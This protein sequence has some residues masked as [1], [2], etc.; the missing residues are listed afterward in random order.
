MNEEY[1]QE[2][3]VTEVTENTDAQS[4]EEVEEGIELTDTSEGVEEDKETIETDEKEKVKTY[5]EDD[6]EKIVNERIN[7]ILPNKIERERRKIDREYRD[8]LSKYE[9]T[10]SI[11]SAG[12]EKN[13]IDNINSELRTFYKNQGVDIPV[14]TKPNYSDEDEKAL[15]EL[16][17]NKII[18]L[19]F[20][21][22]QDEANRLADIGSDKMT[23]REKAMFNTLAKELTTQ[24][25][26]KE[27]AKIG[28]KGEILEDLNFRQFSSQFNSNVPIQKVY[29]MYAKINNEKPDYENPGSMKGVRKPGIKEYYSPEEIERLTDEELDNP[30]VWDAVR[31]SMTGQS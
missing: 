8:K 4:V 9:E 13:G 15:G 31:R 20:D 25:N 28:V 29:E 10:E 14:Q 26:K 16:E 11:L 3:P 30:K 6:L 5:T 1:V 27:L 2:E 7:S 19:G 17:A 22:M 23:V 21:E 24:K 18:E 12:L